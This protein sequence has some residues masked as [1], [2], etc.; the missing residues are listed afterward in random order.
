MPDEQCLPIAAI[1]MEV[2]YGISTEGQSLMGRVWMECW[3]PSRED[4]DAINRGQPIFIQIH[5][6]ALPPISMYTLD[7]N[8][9]SNNAY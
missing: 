9:Q 6:L 2:S 5:S 4:I 1:P 8:G 7:E 3:K